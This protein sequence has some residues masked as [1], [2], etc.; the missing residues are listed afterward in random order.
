MVRLLLAG[1]SDQRPDQSLTLYQPTYNCPGESPE[2][3]RAFAFFQT[4]TVPNMTGFF[5][6]CL[7]K[8]LILPMS[9]SE[10]A[11]IHAVVA[12]ATLHEDLQLRGAPLSRENLAN[13]RQKFAVSQYGRSLSALNERRYSQDPKLRDTIL[14]C[15]LL[16]VAIDVIRGQ[17]D[18]ALLHL[19][20][21][22][23][24]IEE[25][26]QHSHEGSGVVHTAAEKT[27]L[28]IITRLETQ[29]VFFGPPPGTDFA[30]SFPSNGLGGTYFRT[31]HEVQVALDRLLANS[32]RFFAAVYRFPVKDRV[33]RLH[34][35]LSDAQSKLIAQLREFRRQLDMSMTHWLHPTSL[36]EQRGLDLIILHHI[37]FSILVKTLLCGDDQSVYNDYSSSFQQMVNLSN[38]ISQSFKDESNSSL[39]P[40][41]ILDMG[42]IPSLFFVCWKC[43]DFD[44]RYQALS[45]LEEWPHREGIWDSRLFSIFARQVI[46]LEKAAMDASKNPGSWSNIPQDHSLEVSQDQ[47]HVILR[48]QTQ[49]PGE[50]V[51]KQEIVIP[52]DEDD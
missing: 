18:S 33:A 32:I 45:V 17:Y 29:S 11:V 21:G 31:V 48:Y 24:I 22:L 27:L 37:S 46:Q 49:E 40:T 39:R 9:H 2:E 42:I 47:S 3:R 28:A 50:Q 23:A 13:R 52:L 6:S 36:K 35:G 51:L 38:K 30:M 20:N 7:W 43:R 1:K 26:C 41:L 25:E 10:R 16:F 4:A 12:L 19:K 44:L 15:C 34:P 8:D 14:T 5:D